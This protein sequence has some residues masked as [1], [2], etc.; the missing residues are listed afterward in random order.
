VA[1]QPAPPE[2]QA[3]QGQPEPTPPPTTPTQ[4]EPEQPPLQQEQEFQIDVPTG[5]RKPK[6]RSTP[7]IPA[8]RPTSTIRPSAGRLAMTGVDAR[9][10]AALGTFM[11]GM[12]LTLLGITLPRRV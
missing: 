6:P 2:P 4:P 8:L 1:A 9:L 3:A 7:M 10:L 5:H 11:I 12:G